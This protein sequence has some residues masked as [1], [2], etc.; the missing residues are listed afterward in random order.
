MK[1]SPKFFAYTL[2]M[3]GLSNTAIADSRDK[4]I[5]LMKQQIK[6]LMQEVER[7]QHERDALAKQCKH[8]ALTFE[9]KLRSTRETGTLTLNIF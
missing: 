2:L 3:F 7:L 8:D 9:E 5:E 1:L 6:I 4:D